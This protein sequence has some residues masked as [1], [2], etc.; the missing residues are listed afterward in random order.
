MGA[1]RFEGVD[2]LDSLGKI[3]ELHTQHYKEDFELDKKLILDLA[4][5]GSPEDKHILWMSRP[6]GTY[7]MW[8]SNVYLEGSIENRTLR[9]YHE[10]TNDPILIYA[11][12]L[13]DVK[14]GTVTGT[15]YPLDYP[16]F[17]ERV[18]QLACPIERAA[19]SFQDGTR[20]ILPYRSYQCEVPE[21]KM[22]HGNLKHMSF[23]PESNQELLMILRKER[24][25][26]NYHTKPGNIQEY[27]DS[28]KKSTL[29]GK[30]AEAKGSVS[31]PD[32][33]S[34]RKETK[35]R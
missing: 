32:R 13:E 5:S 8:E 20:L 24:F 7:C 34:P 4:A 16:V 14:D 21:L 12:K 25:K 22:A 1:V 30:L 29:R 6:C 33:Q 9:F 11:V 19:L 3:M 18:K 10:Q 17:V 2:I 27:I 28:L 23:L 15:I 35:E 26:I 31:P